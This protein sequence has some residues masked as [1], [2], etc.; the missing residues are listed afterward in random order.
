[1]FYDYD[2]LLSRHFLIAFIIAERG[3]GK[4]FG[5]KVAVLKKFLKTG[6]QFMYVR[7]Y[8]TELDS[9]LATFWNDLQDNGYFEDLENALN[10]L[11]EITGEVSAD[12]VLGSIFS[13]FCVG[14]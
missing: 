10:Y 14:K 6:E 13:R 11:G 3:V 7:R 8:K 9:S 4:T 12:D 5:A 1:M 2:K